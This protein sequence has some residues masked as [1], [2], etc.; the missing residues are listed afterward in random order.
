MAMNS[1][2]G[3]TLQTATAAA[4]EGTDMESDEQQLL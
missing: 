3:T 2:D 4:V 1:A